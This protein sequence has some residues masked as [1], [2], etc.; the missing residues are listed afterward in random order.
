[1]EYIVTLCHHIFYPWQYTN[2]NTFEDHVTMYLLLFIALPSFILMIVSLKLKFS[3]RDSHVTSIYLMPFAYGLIFM[4]FYWYIALPVSV[5]ISF[6]INWGNKLILITLKQEEMEGI[7]AIR[8]SERNKQRKDWNEKSEYEKLKYQ[9][10]IQKRLS[11]EP[12]I[13]IVIVSSYIFSLVLIFV[14]EIIGLK[15]KAF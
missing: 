2:I 1:M 15:Y 10:E 4:I 5:L 7:T 9:E 3:A 11:K 6:L 14:L 8:T 12:N 13:K